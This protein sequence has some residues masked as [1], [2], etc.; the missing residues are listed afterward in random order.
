MSYN[1]FLGGATGQALKLINPQ[2]QELNLG[3]ISLGR[4]VPIK[5]T[6]KPITT[7]TSL[8]VV[9]PKQ[10][11]MKRVIAP[12]NKTPIPRAA[13]IAGKQGHIMVVQKSDQP[14]VK[15]VQSGTT[16][17]PNPT[18]TISFHQAQEMGLITAM[19]KFVSQGSTGKQHALLL[20]KPPAKAIKIVPQ[21]SY[22]QNCIFFYVIIFII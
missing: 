17:L 19:T 15:M 11:V 21:V 1:S 5:S 16:T 18:K 2:G 4:T 8:S 3:N 22:C 10:V 14:S 9:Q 20:N 13:T 7:S 6:V 12:A